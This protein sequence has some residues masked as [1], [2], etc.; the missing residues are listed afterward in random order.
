MRKLL[1]INDWIKA[2]ITLEEIELNIHRWLNHDE[3]F[4]DQVNDNAQ[5]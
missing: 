2:L 1:E 5:Q 4:D 3:G